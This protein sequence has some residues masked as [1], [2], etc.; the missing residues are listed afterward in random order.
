MNPID[1]FIVAGGVPGP[2]DPIY[3]ET[4]GGPKTLIPI[5]G[6]PMVQWVIDALDEAETIGRIVVVGLDEASGLTAVKPLSFFPDQ[7]G[8]FQN[9]VAGIHGLAALDPEAEYGLAASGDIPGIRGDMVDWLV[10]ES[11]SK[12][13]DVHYVIGGREVVDKRF[14]ES[15]RT[16]IPFRD[17]KYCGG[18][19]HVISVNKNIAVP[20]IWDRLGEARKNPARMAAVIG[21]KIMFGLLFRRLTVEGVM[22][23][24]CRRFRITGRAVFAP[25]AEM[26]MDVDKPHHLEVMRRHLS[27]RGQ[28]ARDDGQTERKREEQ[29]EDERRADGWTE[30]DREGDRAFQYSNRAG[31]KR[32]RE[33]RPESGPAGGKPVEGNEE[34]GMDGAGGGSGRARKTD[35]WI[36]KDAEASARLRKMGEGRGRRI[37]AVLAHTGDT[38]VL[39]PAVGLIWLF[40][41]GA[42]K[43]GAWKTGLA[44]VIGTFV[45][46]LLKLAFKR[47]RPDGKWGTFDRLID[48]HSFPSGHAN[49]AAVLAVLAILYYSPIAAAAVSIWALAVG[50]SRVALGMHY[51]SDVL[52]GWLVGAAVGLFF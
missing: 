9:V 28:E 43:A 25:Y 17:G 20:K 46:G 44:L 3:S 40:G 12:N 1:A 15:R 33:M 14:P 23:A 13:L 18:G 47:R 42:L 30:P 49:R 6:K 29:I 41:Q 16:F 51:L 27:A 24:F 48:P 34:P 45:T 39:F 11:V 19:I 10:R 8:L 22:K 38:I 7:G 2:K 4:R 32:D 36:R 5:N 26:V 35:G 31:H 37:F 52:A 50:V 21:P